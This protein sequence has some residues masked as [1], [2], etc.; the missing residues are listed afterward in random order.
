L[1]AGIPGAIAAGVYAAIILGRQK[2]GRAIFR[3]PAQ[4]RILLAVLWALVLY[5]ALDSTVFTLMLRSFASYADRSGHVGSTVPDPVVFPSVERS[6]IEVQTISLT[7]LLIYNHPLELITLAAFVAV[8]W[9][10]L[11]TPAFLWLFPQLALCLLSLHMGARMTMFGPPVLML[12]LCLAGGNLLNAL[13]HSLRLRLLRKHKQRTHAACCPYDGIEKAARRLLRLGPPVRFAAGLIC[14][15]FLAWPLITPL[16]DYVQG[17]I[18]SREQAEGLSFL[19]NNSPE[20]SMIWN[21]WDWGYAAHHFSRR[22][23]IADGARHGGPSLYLPSAVYT[24]AD[25]RFARQIIKY[26][27]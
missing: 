4:S 19:K 23:A 5:C 14:T 24:T 26:T 18:I 20:E 10:M 25:P 21:W 15:A 12:A 16:P 1:L 7:E 8:T 2:S 6:I 22:Q 3:I 13:L 11:V 27:A 9:R 17:P